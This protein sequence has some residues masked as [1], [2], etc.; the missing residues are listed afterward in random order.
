M[1]YT[2]VGTED[3]VSCSSLKFPISDDCS[4]SPSNFFHFCKITRHLYI[5]HYSYLNSYFDFDAKPM[6]VQHKT[7]TNYDRITIIFNQ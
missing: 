2:S 5:I 7:I 1:T 3:F 6:S 4:S